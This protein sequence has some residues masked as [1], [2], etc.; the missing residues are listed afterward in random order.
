MDGF[1]SVRRVRRNF[2]LKFGRRL[3]PQVHHADH[4]SRPLIKRAVLQEVP[5]FRSAP[6]QGGV[7]FSAFQQVLEQPA[8]T[9]GFLQRLEDG[10]QGRMIAFVKFQGGGKGQVPYL[11]VR[12][13]LVRES[14]HEGERAQSVE[15]SRFSAR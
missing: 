5:G 1:F 14:G 8:F 13:A 12:R 3:F 4:D 15:S 6:G 11:I 7:Y 10:Q 9:G 2:H